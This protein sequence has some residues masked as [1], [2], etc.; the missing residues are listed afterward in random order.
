MTEET[1]P[2]N[3]QHPI[4]LVPDFLYESRHEFVERL[5]Y[6]LWEERGRPVGS[7]DVDWFAAEQAVE[8]SLAA[9]GM[10]KPSSNEPQNLREKIYR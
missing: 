3:S 5:A 10:I 7:P 1:R 6:Q 4:D 9:S 2:A 8:V